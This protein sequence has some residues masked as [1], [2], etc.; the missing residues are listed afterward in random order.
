MRE[1]GEGGGEANP[2]PKLLTSLG[3]EGGELATPPNPK[4]VSRFFLGGGGGR[5]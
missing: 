3:R 1:E 2:N 5:G 4:L